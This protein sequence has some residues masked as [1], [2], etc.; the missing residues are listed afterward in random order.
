MPLAMA[1]SGEVNVI[2]KIGGKEETQRFLNCLGFVVGG[3]VTVMQEI[4]GDV[5]VDVKDSRVA[6]SKNLA[7]RIM[8]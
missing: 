3:E 1:K 8:V 7:M 5:I 2:R 6:I 4:G